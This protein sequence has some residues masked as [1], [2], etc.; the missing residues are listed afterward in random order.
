MMTKKEINEVAGEFIGDDEI[1]DKE[2]SKRFVIETLVEIG[3]YD[4]EEI[5]AIWKQVEFICEVNEFDI[6]LD[7]KIQQYSNEPN[8]W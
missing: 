3:K 1:N 2:I 7:G 8:D 5:E 4:Q 6:V